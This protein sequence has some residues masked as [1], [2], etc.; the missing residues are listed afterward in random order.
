M[1][2]RPNLPGHCLIEVY[3]TLTRL[4]APFRAAPGIVSA[5]LRDQFEDRI[6]VPDAAT[7]AS[8]PD[9][10]AAAGLVGGVAYDALIGVTAA[11]AGAQLATL[12]RRAARAYELLE[13]PFA[14]V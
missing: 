11:A 10:L 6:I 3:S 9:R 13:I 5:Y 7:V 14:I 12:D 4:P 2:G 8:L 1:D